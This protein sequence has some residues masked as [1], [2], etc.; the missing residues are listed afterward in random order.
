MIPLTHSLVLSAIIFVIGLFGVM[1][2]RN[3]LFMIF[4]LVVMLNGTL[5]AIVS[6]SHYW[7][8]ND[9]QMNTILAVSSIIAECSIGLALVFQMYYRRKTLNIDSLS[10]MKE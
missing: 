1:I 5:I 8:Q 7:L 2:R 3:L 4:S 9:G 6:A 10:E